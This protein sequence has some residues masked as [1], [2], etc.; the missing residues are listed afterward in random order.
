[1]NDFFRIFLKFNYF[2]FFIWL[3]SFFIIDATI[4]KITLCD[5]HAAYALL[6][7]FFYHLNVSK[8]S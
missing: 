4:K 7:F 5:F 3:G 1:M 6:S 2:Q 8:T